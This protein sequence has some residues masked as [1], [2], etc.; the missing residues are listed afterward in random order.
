M[1]DN[2]WIL[3]AA[4]GIMVAVIGGLSLLGD[5]YTL[6][7]IKSKTV[8]DGQHGT[9]RWATDAEL[10][11]TYALV[12]F[13]VLDWRAGKYLPEAQGLVLGST[14]GKH[15]ITAL[16]DK[17]DVHCLMIGASG[18][19]K[20]AYF[21]YPN[22]EYAC[23]C[24]MSFFASD[25]KGDLARNYGAVA[26]RYYGYH[27]SVVD[28]RNPTRSDGYNLL[29][30][31]NHYGYVY[32][33][34]Y[35]ACR[36]KRRQRLRELPRE[37]TPSNN[38][39]LPEAVELFFVEREQKRKLKE[40][41]VS[42]YRYVVRQY[43]QPQLGAAPL[44]AL[45]EQRV[46]DFYR[47]LQEQGLSAKSTRDVGVLL[48]AILRMAAKRGCFCTGLNAELP[49]YR[50]RQVE[51]FTEPEI[52]RLAHHIVNEPDLTGLGVLLT[53]N[54]GL[55]LGELCALRWSDIDLHAGFVRVE[56][57]VQRIYEKG[58]TRLI[59]QP[60][61]SESSLRRIPLPTDILSLLAAHRPE[62]AGSFCLLTSS[63]DPLEPRTMQNR[64][65][66]LLKRAGVPYRN[67]HALRHTYATRCI[68][69][70]VD[71]KSVSEMLGH[72]DV[73]I[74]LQTYVHVSL[75]HKQQAVQSI[76]FLPICGNADL[77]PSEIPSGAAKA[78][79]RHGAAAQIP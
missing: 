23:A 76:C 15:G 77:A 32:A 38:M 47:K 42:R 29:T 60:P 71:V 45:T 73:R 51:I 40:S 7:N 54:S 6:N 56:R 16:V 37:I 27:V 46:A 66:S 17:D 8:G 49:A 57:E 33:A 48:R 75:R 22:L 5:H 70:N 36:E 61:K 12:P 74:T 4:A 28:L 3:F 41:T 11:K 68:E 58:C 39:T 55:R 67:F 44:Y 59:V 34:T 65:R 78:A 43:I 19:G 31:I 24:G 20:T 18:V 62:N 50:K 26:A 72:S 1:T 64:Y 14:S 79:A 10:R 52:L 21:L 35:S 69:Q 9:A 53:L 2:L 63:G 30:L 13:Q 25:T